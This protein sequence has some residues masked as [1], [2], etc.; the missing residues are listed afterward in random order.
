MEVGEAWAEVLEW[1]VFEL[2]LLEVELLEV[3]LLLVVEPP[4]LANAK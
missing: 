3:E 4:P 1:L 2:E